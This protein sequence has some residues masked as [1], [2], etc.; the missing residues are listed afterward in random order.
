MY[1]IRDQFSFT[2]QHRIH[3]YGKW[4]PIEQLRVPFDRYDFSAFAFAVN[5]L[6]NHSIRIELFAITNNLGDFVLHSH[7]V[8]STNKFIYDSGDGSVTAEVES[9]LLQVD[10][11]RSAITK[12]FA[13]CLSLVNWSLALGA[14][15][16]TA[17]VAFGKLESNSLVVPLPFGAPIAI[18]TVRS[19]YVSSPPFGASIGMSRTPSLPLSPLTV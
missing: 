15:Y 8:A 3:K 6:T 13:I 18:A 7:D 1:S 4:D 16:I 11:E 9:R 2:A 19:L 5:P 12:V 10:I 14:V 17:L